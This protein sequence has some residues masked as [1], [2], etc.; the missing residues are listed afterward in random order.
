M[1]EAEFDDN[2][3]LPLPIC[4]LRDSPE[5]GETWRAAR[6]RGAGA[7]A[8]FLLGSIVAH[9]SVL[10]AIPAF[11]R[12]IGMKNAVVLEVVLL[13][14]FPLAIA[15]RKPAAPPTADRPKHAGTANLVMPELRD[16]Q[17]APE[18]ELRES[19]E[20]E[21]AFYAVEPESISEPAGTAHAKGP[22]DESVAL[23]LAPIGAGYLRNPAP[24]YPEAARRSGEQGMVT[25]RVRVAADGSASG[26]TVEKSSGSPH[27]D[28]AALEAVKA[29]RFAPARRGANAIE[30]WMLVP[31]VFRLDGAS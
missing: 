9:A 14:A 26:V 23:Q 1:G 4:M 28:A 16:R 17:R 6:R 13:K 15:P 22:L 25:L 7:F 18:L 27:L 29:W 24:R 10:M 5:A 20:I 31:I 11:E 21:G 19:R 2:P 30:S 12:A 3:I 8:I